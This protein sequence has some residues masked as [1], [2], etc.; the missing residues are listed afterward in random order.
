MKQEP[1]RTRK[2]LILHPGAIGD[3]LLAL[4]AASFMKEVLGLDEVDWIGH[5][6]YVSFYPGRSR[7]DRIRSL[8]TAAL[9]RLFED[10]KSFDLAEKDPLFSVFGGYEQVVSFLGGSDPHFEQNLIYTVH[11]CQ[12][13]N[14]LVLPV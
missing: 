11:C 6:E 10:A 2:G 9:H 4:P 13:A 3:C 1:C 5:T 12:S 8:E 7:V 14:V